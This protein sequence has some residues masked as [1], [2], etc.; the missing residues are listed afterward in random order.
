MILLKK[1]LLNKKGKILSFNDDTWVDLTNI[2]MVKGRFKWGQSTN[3][4]IKFKGK[5]NFGE[6]ITGE[7][8]ILNPILDNR[9][10]YSKFKVLYN[11]IEYYILQS[12]IRN[13]NFH[14]LL[15]REFK[16]EIGTTFNDKKGNI[17]IIDRKSLSKSKRLYKYHC[18]KCGYEDWKLEIDFEKGGSTRCPCCCSAPKVVIPGINDIPTEAPWMVK[19]FPGGYDEAKLYTYGSGKEIDFICPD[20]GCVKRMSIHT[21]YECGFTCS[22]QGRFSYPERVMEEFL[23]QLKIDYKRQL[24]RKD[25]CWI[26]NCLYDFYLYGYNAIIETH[27]RQHYEETTLTTRTLEE[28]QE[29]DRFKEALAKNNGVKNYIVLDC[30]K[31][32]I[33]WIKKSIMNSNLPKLL[34]FTE[35]NIDWNLCDK[36]ALDNK[37]REISEFYEFHKFDMQKKEIAK[38]FNISV[39]WLMKLLKKGNKHGWCSYKADGKTYVKKEKDEQINVVKDGKLLGIFKTPKDIENISVDKFGVKLDKQIIRQ[40][41]NGNYK[42]RTYKG[43][44]FIYNK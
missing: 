24:S 43:F 29:N 41:L 39:S 35:N 34:N 23:K 11:N 9:G 22:C 38:Y 15:H 36:K 28:E 42:C 7:F 17:T 33:E 25:F 44:E 20:C 30:R 19:Y 32:D 10:Q 6:Y 3:K 14:N 18:N 2:D 37:I 4:I 21:L 40:F 31:S 1:K 16:Y 27:G 13:A 5:N 8:K 26:E 12:S